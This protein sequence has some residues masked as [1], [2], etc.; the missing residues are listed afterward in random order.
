MNRK[1]DAVFGI[2][3][4][5]RQMSSRTAFHS[6]TKFKIGFRLLASPHAVKEIVLGHTGGGGFVWYAGSAGEC[7][8]IRKR[9]SHLTLA[10]RVGNLFDL[11]FQGKIVDEE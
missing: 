10:A 11:V 8:L 3:L 5:F 7:M 9:M 2:S 6:L 4:S 1:P